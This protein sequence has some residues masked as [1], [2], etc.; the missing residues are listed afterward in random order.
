[1]ALVKYNGKEN[2]VVRIN[3]E[4]KLIKPNKIFSGPISFKDYD[5]FEVIGL[6]KN[7]LS[8]DV[9][10]DKAIKLE[11]KN[12]FT[13]HID[14][15]FLDKT[16]LP[17]V[18]ICIVTK[19]KG[20][21]DRCL[22]SIKDFCEYDEFEVLLCDTGTEEKEVLELYEDYKKI[23]GEKFKVFMGHEYNFSKNNNFLAEQSTGDVL[24]FMNNDVFLTYDA[25]S[26]MVG[27]SLSSNLGCIGHR[28]VYD[29]DKQSIQHDGQV[30][31]N[32][33]GQWIGPGHHNYNRKINELDNKDV[34]VEGVT[35]AFLMIRKEIFNKVKGFDEDYKDIYQ[36]VDLN[37]KVY[38]EGYENFCIRE[39]SIIH[40]DHSSRKGDATADS[41]LDAMKYQRD[42]IMKGLMNVRRKP[43]YSI[44]ICATNKTQLETL[45][46]SIKSREEYELV[47]INNRSNYFWASEALNTLTK[48]SRGEILFWM[49]QDVTFDSYEPFAGVNDTINKLD[50]NFGILGPAG[51]QV[52]SKGAIKGVDFSSLKYNFDYMRVQTLDEFCL[53]GKRSNNLEFGEYLDHFHFYGADICL[54]SLEKGL[55]NY[56]I[57]IPITHHSGGDGN[58]KKR[59]GYESY[60]K[61]G[62]KMYK[63]WYDKFP[64][65]STT[66]VHFRNKVVYWF[67]GEILGLSP[68]RET[69]EFDN[70]DETENQKT[71]LS[72]KD[73]RIEKFLDSKKEGVTVV[74]NSVNE[75]EGLG[76]NINDLRIELKDKNYEILIADNFSDKQDVI[77]YYSELSKDDDIKIFRLNENNISKLNNEITKKY[78]AYDKLMFVDSKIRIEKG[79]VDKFIDSI[80]NKTAIVGAEVCDMNDKIIKKGIRM[81]S[82][83]DGFEPII[84]SEGEVDS[85]DNSCFM[86]PTKLFVDYS[87][88]EEKF[89][90]FQEVDLCLV[91]KRLGYNIDVIG[92]VFKETMYNIDKECSSYKMFMERWGKVIYK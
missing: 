20:V 53:I 90:K 45:I 5:N 13:P 87:G 12:Y 69:I 14:I 72:K 33:K 86:I 65:I 25:V 85:I 80:K 4:R 66:T 9:S 17:K 48:T 63:K 40:V 77:E 84:V 50:G 30:L 41:P 81:E 22:K 24:L 37:L 57:K 56:V 21:I 39:K 27:Y 70:I 88:F 44:L 11:I 3:G 16:D 92:K 91:M 29:A 38:N 15:D 43:R 75:K 34:F 42:W 76:K 2:V 74:I 89:S 79:I 82:V 49:H 60:I 18:S 35:A 59:G 61:Q 68:S 71:F 55:N 46:G 78:V 36:D 51:V 32:E 58:L 67:L 64:D 8:S 62:R 6:K 26:K 52:G 19:G 10:K 83:E 47:F 7:E 31:Y 73:F 28:L 1:M 23:W 54:Q